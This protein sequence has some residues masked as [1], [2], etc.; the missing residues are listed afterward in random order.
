MTDLDVRTLKYAEGFHNASDEEKGPWISDDSTEEQLKEMQATRDPHQAQRADNRDAVAQWRRHDCGETE[1]QHALQDPEMQK[2]L[3]EQQNK[4][5]LIMARAEEQKLWAQTNPT[6][7][8]SMQVNPNRYQLHRRKQFSSSTGNCKPRPRPKPRLRRHSLIYKHM[9]RPSSSSKVKPLSKTSK[10]FKAQ[11]ENLARVIYNRLMA[12]AASQFDGA[13]NI[14]QETVD[15]IKQ[16]SFAQASQMLRELYQ[17][18]AQQQLQQAGTA[19]RTSGDLVTVS[20]PDSQKANMKMEFKNYKVP[21]RYYTGNHQMT[22][23]V[24]QNQNPHRI[25]RGG[26]DDNQK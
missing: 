12:D 18:R 25:V 8:G 26:L 13:V 19:Q 4:R 11:I 21:N 3:L 20:S 2:M 22:G 16:S 14:P 1:Q 7:I 15:R 5:R 23:V 6:L 24:L 10:P 17:R 9:R